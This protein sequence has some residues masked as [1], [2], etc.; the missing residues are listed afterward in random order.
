M[1]PAN[2]WGLHDMHGNVSEWCADYWHDNYVGA[3]VDGRAWLSNPIR[4]QRLLRGGS[5]DDAPKWCDSA[6]RDSILPSSC[7][8]N[9]GFRVVCLPQEKA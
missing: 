3:P 2:A 4:A 1:F 6:S 8:N 7:N 9:V 5:W